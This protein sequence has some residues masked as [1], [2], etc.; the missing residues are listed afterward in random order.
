MAEDAKHVNSWDLTGA[1]LRG[2][3]VA[4]YS[5]EKL[6]GKLPCECATKEIGGVLSR[7][8]FYVSIGREISDQARSRALARR[9][10][11]AAH[12]DV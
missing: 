4:V 5:S 7:R 1:C 9:A 3:A 10:R 8:V 12:P 11:R 2:I 6:F